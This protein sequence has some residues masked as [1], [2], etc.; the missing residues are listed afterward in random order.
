MKSIKILIAAAL[1]F[2]AVNISNA[3]NEADNTASKSIS[4]GVKGGVNFAT[5]TGDDFDSPDMRTSFHVGALV[6]MPL[7]DIF[8]LQLEAM[9]S[10]QGFKSDIEGS[11][12][13]K[14]EYQLDYVNVPVLAKL[15]VTKG[16]SFE[17]GP[18]F[19]FKVNEE[20]DSDPNN[21]PGDTDVDVAED[22]DFGVA[23]GLTFQTDMGLFASGRYIYG[24]S[25]VVEDTDAHNSVF[26]ISLGYKF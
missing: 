10:G 22:F 3:Q 25:D 19:S 18:Q 1:I 2:T 14:V 12:G 8:S 21:D 5:I 9:Y 17:V 11:D 20:V 23:G 16:L 13:D 15:Y 4:F 26:Q 6:E 7:A 24:M